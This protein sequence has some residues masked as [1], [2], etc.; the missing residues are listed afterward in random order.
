MTPGFDQRVYLLPFDHRESFQARLFG[1]RCP[2]SAEQT[3]EVVAAKLAIYDG[4]RDAIAGDA[5]RDDVG[6]LVDEQFGAAILRDARR[7]GYITAMPLEASGQEEFHLQY[8]EDFARHIEA[9]EPTFCKVLVRYDPEGD[10]ARNRRQSA[11]LRRVSEFLHRT[12][13]KFMFE[14]LVPAEEADLENSTDD[15]GAHDRSRRPQHMVDSIVALQDAGV[16][17]DVWKIEGLD[18]RADCERVVMAAQRGG[19]DG[20]GC[21]ILGRG[22]EERTIERWLTTA[23]GVPGFIGFAVGRTTFWDA[24]VDWRAHRITRES[25]VAGIA[26]RYRKWLAIFQNAEWSALRDCRALRR[27]ENEGGRI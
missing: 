6:V 13:R 18:R 25:A 7:K 24:L 15:H 27:W 4:F 19:R 14:L 26:A 8:G 23:A 3:T 21:I 9:F 20:V 12:R 11:R 10:P 2:L 1:W 17:P 5:P 16:E 22:A